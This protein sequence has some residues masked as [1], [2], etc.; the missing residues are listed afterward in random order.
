MKK[1]KIL[2]TGGAGFIGSNFVH[3]FL[4]QHPNYKVVNL[5][6]LTYAGRLE[7][8]KDIEK[9]PRYR[10]IKGDIGDDKLVKDIFRKE[11]PDFVVHFAAES[12]V[13]RSISE[14]KIF[15]KT[16]V[17][18]TQVLLEA[19]RIYG[20]KK[21]LFVST[22]EAYGSIKKGKFK[23]TDPLNPSSPYSASKAAADLLTLSYY[24]TF[25]LP[26]LITRSSNN[27]GPCQYPEKMIPL[28]ITNL[29]ENKK[30]PLYGAGENVREWI[31]VL[32]N[33]VAIDFILHQGK[34]G[35]I[36]NIG[37][38]HELSNLK[39]TKMI[40]AELSKDESSI[41]YV[42]DRPGHDFRYA[43]E[44]KKIRKLGWR[45]KYNFKRAL[46]ET[47]NWYKNNFFWGKKLKQN[48]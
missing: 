47:I 18:G 1:K 12:F 10:F 13:D 5:D 35:E 27:F 25:N 6:L 41:K 32:D 48:I 24:R 31:Y 45:P 4:K 7:N 28:F 43:L 15:V 16:N 14:P 36:Y 33:C 26:V 3:Y 34:I 29:L 17:L 37:S 46:K 40:L 21:F 30:V 44:T 11:R 39:I 19:A 42:K 8:L 20:L 22:D 23:E 38:G 9:D 2:I